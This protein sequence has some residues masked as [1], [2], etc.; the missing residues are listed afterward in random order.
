MRDSEATARRDEKRADAQR[1]L[2][3]AVMQTQSTS[4]IDTGGIGDH[5]ESVAA[6]YD[7]ATKITDKVLGPGPTET[8]Q[9]T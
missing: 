4:R 7:A 6:G 1:L 3:N 9:G 2:D 5:I 8:A